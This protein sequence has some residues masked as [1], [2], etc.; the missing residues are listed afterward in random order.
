MATSA[1]T[2]EV[3][4]PAARCDLSPPTQ[5]WTRGNLAAACFEAHPEPQLVFD[6]DGAVVVANRAARQLI[7]ELH[8]PRALAERLLAGGGAALRALAECLSRA[9]R[10]QEPSPEFTLALAPGMR[11]VVQ[12][13]PL[14]ADLDRALLIV[15]RREGEARAA[16]DR[17][18]FTPAERQVAERLASGMTV[19]E[20]AAQRG[21]T[22]ETVRCHLKQAF[23]KA[24]V[25]RQAELVAVMLGR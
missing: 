20:I 25:H 14:G 2:R 9:I 21:V 24:G 4:P 11:L 5:Q 13:C 17:F 12:A 18:H 8:G 6:S 3:V 10:A 16:S 22:I 19:A 1:T 23:S 15:K 7:D